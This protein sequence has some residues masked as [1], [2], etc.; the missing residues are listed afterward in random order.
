MSRRSSWIAGPPPGR[1]RYWVAWRDDDEVRVVPIELSPA[2]IH[3]SDPNA[4]LL[5]KTLTGMAYDYDANRNNITHHMP[6]VGPT[7][8]GSGTAGRKA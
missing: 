5:I 2:V 1:G 4:R 7:A 8:P 3:Y 6:L